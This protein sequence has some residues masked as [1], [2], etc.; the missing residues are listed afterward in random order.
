MF[1]SELAAM[2]RAELASG[3]SSESDDTEAKE[4]EQLQSKRLDRLK[5][6]E[7]LRTS[8]NDKENDGKE[9]IEENSDDRDMFYLLKV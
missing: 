3:D 6:R 2:Q 8:L 7:D 4:S 5:K 9:L 1:L